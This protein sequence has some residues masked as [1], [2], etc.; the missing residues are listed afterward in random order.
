LAVTVS[1][2][3]GLTEDS[4]LEAHNTPYFGAAFTATTNG[5]TQVIALPSLPECN[6]NWTKVSYKRGKSPEHE[7]VTTKEYCKESKYWL[8]Q[9][10]AS[11]R[12]T[13]LQEVQKTSQ[14]SSQNILKSM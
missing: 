3:R 8:N 14:R 11:T 12:F 5:H 7:I 9:S 1:V 10:M 4:C 13:V 2:V 6:V